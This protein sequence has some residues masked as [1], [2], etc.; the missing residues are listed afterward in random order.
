VRSL[1]FLALGADEVHRGDDRHEDGEGQPVVP[2][3]LG[4]DRGEGEA[5]NRQPDDGELKGRRSRIESGEK[6]VVAGRPHGARID[7]A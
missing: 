5:G 6:W 4:G 1:V 2:C 7:R 3:D